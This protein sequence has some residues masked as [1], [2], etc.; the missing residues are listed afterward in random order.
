MIII[1]DTSIIS[2]LILVGRI[3]L[4][5]ELFDEIIVPH[6][7][8]EELL[9]LENY[10]TDVKQFIKSNQVQIMEL[11]RMVFYAE[12]LKILD[13][14]EAQAITLAIELKADL[15]LIDEKKG[16]FIAEQ[17]E[18]KITGLL[19][20]LLLAKQRG[21]IDNVK[22]VMDDLVHKSGFWIGEKLYRTV[23]RKA[24]EW[25]IMDII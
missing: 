11:S 19:G 14:G 17:L 20:L 6:A 10:E 2:G 22:Q 3:S 18:L 24:D 21:F 23:L 16:R 1:S 5:T 4:L 12:L 9:K 8:Q 13:K 7:V 15:L 25:S